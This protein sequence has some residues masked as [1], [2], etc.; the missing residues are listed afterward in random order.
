LERFQHPQHP[1]EMLTN[2]DK[3]TNTAYFRPALGGDMAV[4]RGMAKF[5]L[6]WERDAQKA[7]EPAVF[8]HDFLNAHSTN[9]LEYLGVVDDT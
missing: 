5:L 8:D 3:P 9:V 7:G 6:Q 4:L 2:G 1:L